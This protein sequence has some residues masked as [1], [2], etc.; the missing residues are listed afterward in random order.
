MATRKL[1]RASEAR[2]RPDGTP[3]RDLFGQ[4]PVTR[5]EVLALAAR[6]GLTG[7]RLESYIN[8]YCIADRVAQMKARGTL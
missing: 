5:D 7:F 3:V 2:Y 1:T 8:G 4:I 6:S